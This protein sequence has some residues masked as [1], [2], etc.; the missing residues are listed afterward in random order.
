MEPGLE[1]GGR[2]RLERLLGEGSFGEVWKAADLLRDQPVA[3]KFLHREMSATKPHVVSKFRQEAKIAARLQH[4]GI[5]RVD[6]FGTHEGQWFLVMEFLQ[7]HNLAVELGNHPHGMPMDRAVD[8][9]VQLA[10]ALVA[11]HEMG[12]VHRDLKPANLMV[13]ADGRLKVCDF[14][15]ARMA[16]A[17]TVQ[18]FTGRV[19]TPAYMAP[20]QWLGEPVDHRTDLYALGGILFTLL[21]GHPPFGNESRREL[22]G[23]HLHTPPPHARDERPETP[24]ALDEL[25][26]ELLAKEPQGRPERTTDVLERLRGIQRALPRPDTDSSLVPAVAAVPVHPSSAP[27]LPP[28]VSGAISLQAALP[29]PRVDYSRL[30]LRFSLNGHEDGVFSVAFSPDGVSLATA[31]YDGT[32]KLW[33]A[34]TGDLITTFTGHRE[35]VLSVAFSPDGTI[36]A[37]ASHDRTVR[38]WDTASGT[39][40]T[41]LTGHRRSVGSVAFGADSATLATAGHDGVVRL[42]AIRTRRLWGGRIG[43]VLASFTAHKDS[44]RSVA[45]SPDGAA[46]VT[47]SED[48]TA[49]LWSVRSGGLIT[50]FTGHQ[51]WVF[52]AAFNPN[53]AILA[54]GGGD[55]TA[56]LWNVRTGELLATLAGHR[57]WVHSVAFSP[58]GTTLAT[59]GHDGAVRLWD[60]ATGALI[61]TLIGHQKWVFS[62]A[63]SPDGASLATAG[64]DKTVQLWQLR[65]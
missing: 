60:I 11:A 22:M 41:T 49:K 52:S 3:M 56:R 42:W 19:G 50:T 16:D 8:L 29:P 5:T 23:Q 43:K 7:G 39:L 6:N 25:I 35:R 9:A 51:H 36:L 27:S 57:D 32:A 24:E 33:N 38:L 4:P 59:A 47:T 40:I 21:T 18:T 30:L 34:K 13:T 44:I 53:G 12:V 65:D 55:R 58:D 61:T 17:S 54:T 63:F 28:P 14:G 15:V 1:V 62:V 64:Q 45:F 46:L 26:V 10:D 31:G 37:T 48:G 2:Y 20:E